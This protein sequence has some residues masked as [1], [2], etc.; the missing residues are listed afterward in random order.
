MTFPLYLEEFQDYDLRLAISRAID[1]E[2]ITTTIFEGTR[3]PADSYVP[4]TIDGASTSG[5][6]R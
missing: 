1:R 3:I 2:A 4:S 5:Q 6:L